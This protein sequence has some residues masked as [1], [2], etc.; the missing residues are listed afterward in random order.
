[1]EEGLFLWYPFEDN[2]KVGGINTPESVNALLDIK[3]DQ[4]EYDYV[5]LYDDLNKLEEAYNSL[6]SN[7]KI[8]LIIENDIGI[9]KFCTG[10]VADINNTKRSITD[11]IDSH[12]YAYVKFYSIFPNRLEPQLIFSED[13]IPKECM[14]NRYR[15]KYSDLQNVF[16]QESAICDELA[17]NGVL[18]VFANSFFVEI[19]KQPIQNDIKSVTLSLERGVDKATITILK[20]RTVEKK[21]AFHTNNN[22]ISILADNLQKL[23]NRGLQVVDF[24]VEDGSIVMPNVDKILANNYLQGLLSTNKD[25]FLKRMD[26]FYNLICQSSDVVDENELGPI[27]AEGFMDLVPL[28]CFWDGESYLIFD[29]EYVEKNIPAKLMMLRSI[30]I[31]YDGVDFKDALVTP[32]ELYDRYGITNSLEALRKLEASFVTRLRENH[33][34]SLLTI[35]PNEIKENY[36]RIFAGKNDKMSENTLELLMKQYKEHC[37]ETQDADVVLWGA[38]NWC[39]KFLSFY[40]DEFNVI[41]IIDSDLQKQGMSL[42]GIKIRDES[43]LEEIGTDTKVIVCVKNNSDIVKKLID[44]GI[45]NIGVYDAYYEYKRNY[46]FASSNVSAHN[47]KYK[48]GYVSGVFDLYHIGHINM[49]RRAKEQCDYLIVAITSDE[50][51]REHKNREPFIPVDERVECVKSCRYVDEVFVTPYK[52]GGIDDAYR[53]YHYDVQFCGSDYKDNPWWLEQKEWLEQRGSELVFL[54]YTEQTSST[55]IKGLIEKGLL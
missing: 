18:D 35:S 44:R 54:S 26:D 28:N 9:Q 13:Y 19:S 50:Y 6:S 15:P 37:F 21:A 47:K 41:A 55:K 3:N 34:S 24:S 16:L 30:I 29:Q 11:Y 39:D 32:E 17:Q 27:L 46:N 36:Q 49:F 31:M 22:S 25:L 53:K 40:K 23:R 20:D 48:V 33:G 8:L 45:T 2:A 10:G 1:M 4:N 12:L 38:G 51:V 52:Y 43:V 5:I 7:G 14:K 42:Y